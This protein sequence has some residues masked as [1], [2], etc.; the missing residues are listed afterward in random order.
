MLVS[1]VGHVVF[2]DELRVDKIHPL[3]GTC[4]PCLIFLLLSDAI[5]SRKYMNRNQEPAGLYLHID[6]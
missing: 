5:D 6:R 2:R 4:G 3:V 1:L